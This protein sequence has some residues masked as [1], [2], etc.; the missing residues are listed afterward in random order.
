MTVSVLAVAT[1]WRPSKGGVSSFNTEL[2]LALSRTGH[3]AFC[4]VPDATDGEIAEAAAHKITL[5]SEAAHGVMDGS[6]FDIGFSPQLIVGHD[7][8]SG[9]KAARWGERFPKAKLALLL[10]VHPGQI[11]GLKSEES[12]AARDER[13]T[14]S[15]HRIAHADATFAVGQQL[16]AWWQSEH[17][18]FRVHAFVPGLP[19]TLPPTPRVDPPHLRVLFLGR[20]E[21]AELKGV[22]LTTRAMR[23]VVD[24][25]FRNAELVVRGVTP[26]TE[27]EFENYVRRHYPKPRRFVSRLFDP[28]RQAIAD[29]L[30]TSN[31]VLQPSLEEG[32]GLVTLEAIQMETPVLVS[33]RSGV[34]RLIEEVEADN[35]KCFVVASDDEVAWEEA[36]ARVLSDTSQAMADVRRLKLAIAAAHTWDSAAKELVAT[37]VGAPRPLVQ[38]A[39]ISDFDKVKTASASLVHYPRR[40]RGTWIERTEEEA[41]SKWLSSPLPDHENGVL[42]VVGSPGTGKSALLSH[43]AHHAQG[44]NLPMVGIKADLLPPDIGSLEALRS[45]LGFDKPILEILKELA[46]VFGTAVLV[47]DQLDAL[48]EVVDFRTSRLEVLIQLMRGAASIEDVRTIASI[49]PFELQHE[50]RLRAMHSSAHEVRLGGLNVEALRSVLKGVVVPNEVDPEL[51]TPHALDLMAQLSKGHAALFEFPSSLGQL[52]ERYWRAATSDHAQ[53]EATALAV[54]DAMGDAGSLWVREPGSVDS[55]T[56]A[57][58]VSSGMLRKSPDGNLIGFRHQSIFDF[59]RARSLINDGRLESFITAHQRSLEIRPLVR[60][61]LLHLR[62]ADPKAYQDLAEALFAGDSLH[63]RLLVIDT[64]LEADTPSPSERRLIF[65]AVDDDL[66]R[67]RAL[68]GVA[69]RDGWLASLSGSISGWMADY[70]EHSALLASGFLRVEPVAALS[71]LE[72]NWLGTDEGRSRIVGVLSW[73]AQLGPEADPLIERLVPHLV[74]SSHFEFGPIAQ[75]VAQVDPHRAVSLCVECIREAGRAAYAAEPISRDVR[76]FDELLELK[77]APDFSLQHLEPIATELLSRDYTPSAHDF[78]EQLSQAHEQLLQRF[79]K[80]QPDTVIELASHVE[81]DSPLLPAYLRVL[82]HLEGQLDQRVSWLASDPSRLSVDP[83]SIYFLEA[84]RE[85]LRAEH[86]TALDAAIDLAVRY[87]GRGSSESAERRRDRE[88]TNRRYRLCLRDRLPQ[89]SRGPS[90]IAFDEAERHQLPGPPFEPSRGPRVEFVVSPLSQGQLS[91]ANDAAVLKALDKERPSFFSFDEADRPIGGR[92]QILSELRKLA[93][94]DPERVAT[95]VQQL[96]DNGEIDRGRRL[97]TSVAEHHPDPAFIE[98]LALSLRARGNV[99]LEV[100]DECAWALGIISSR[101]ALA[102]SSVTAILQRLERAAPEEQSTGHDPHGNEE[103]PSDEGPNRQ[104]LALFGQRGGG[105]VPSGAYRWLRALVL[106]FSR[107]KAAEPEIWSQAV[108]AALRAAPDPR[109]WAF[110]LSDWERYW[111]WLGGQRAFAL[112]DLVADMAFSPAS[113]RAITRIYACHR[114][115]V[116]S[117]ALKKWIERLV[118]QQL[119]VPAAELAVLIATDPRGETWAEHL[120]DGWCESPVA[121]DIS[122]GVIAATGSLLG[123]SD[124]RMKSSQIAAKWIPS[125]RMKDL[126][127]LMTRTFEPEVWKSDAACEQVLQCVLPRVGEMDAE[128]LRQ[129]VVLLERFV[130]R[131]PKLV[132]ELT[133]QILARALAL[134]TQSTYVVISECLALSTALRLALPGH[135]D[136]THDLF[137]A[138]LA[139]D[140][141]AATDALDVIDGR[142]TGHRNRPRRRRARS[143]VRGRNRSRRRPFF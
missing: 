116:G 141:P 53:Y 36:I 122:T 92:D 57:E 101:K 105:T 41:V 12:I 34:A 103:D 110:A 86:V 47:V 107:R 17:P 5:L 43:L 4:V 126:D 18:R 59:A 37:T 56:V 111:E 98:Q 44:K 115:S 42:L 58:L 133:E 20:A 81:G 70:P 138:A 114:A 77:A 22:Q 113:A 35:A 11:D 9:P 89:S 50:A 75:A 46:A 2:C 61:A 6:P 134:E 121:A 94:Q 136:R 80:E 100:D 127:L 79:A 119:W 51:L 40:T 60:S 1:E 84:V 33:D 72:Q 102:E 52:R 49:R 87:P 118:T 29:D 55:N 14:E 93:E 30:A 45:H 27:V 73:A 135:L 15:C 88:R 31:L 139:A 68:N 62:T 120:L 128:A 130:D 7:R 67:R 66:T 78:R 137:E 143:R 112:L 24:A 106:H 125:M 10:H 23:E 21:D 108:H 132:L 25:G 76:A 32:F 3:Q 85:Q 129:V 90:R 117:S 123:E 54:A 82:A 74:R 39:D 96:R 99:A 83:E 13:I 131:Y 69:L 140:A 95:L 63:V 91:R 28:S 124:R 142:A 48:C 38:P 71:A 19:T 109:I 26:G 8:W 16:R 104:R 97:I 65:K 64:V